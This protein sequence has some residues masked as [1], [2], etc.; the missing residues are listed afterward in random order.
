MPGIEILAPDL[1]D[2]SNGFLRSPNFFLVFFSPGPGLLLPADPLG[3][4][5]FF[6]T[7]LVVFPLAPSSLVR[8]GSLLGVPSLRPV[9]S[10]LWL[11]GLFFGS[12]LLGPLD[13]LFSS[14]SA[15][16]RFGSVRS[17]SVRFGSVRCWRPEDSIFIRLVGWLDFYGNFQFSA[18]IFPNG[19]P[20]FDKFGTSLTSF[21]TEAKFG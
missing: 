5:V 4:F 8:F 16:L 3:I 7:I 13:P 9:G 21:V 12:P 14:S 20:K 19:P 15:S 18:R 10:R 1:T 17:G 6:H 2:T 11:V